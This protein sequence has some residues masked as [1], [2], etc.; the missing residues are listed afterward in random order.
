MPRE[1]DFTRPKW[2]HHVGILRA[3]E[4]GRELR[5]T[6]WGAPVPERGD[7]LVLPE[8]DTG[9]GISARYRVRDVRVAGTADQ[10]FATLDFAPARVDHRDAEPTDAAALAAADRLAPRR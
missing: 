7:H 8:A 1:H 10:W 3:A 4:G 5:V 2:G 9:M 6:G